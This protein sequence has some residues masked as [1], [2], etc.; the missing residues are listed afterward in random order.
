MNAKVYWLDLYKAAMLELN[1]TE[2]RN[3]I[4]L[5]EAV[6]Q[7]RSHELMSS[8]EPTSLEEKCALADAL[9]NLAML[10]R[11]ELQTPFDVSQTMIQAPAGRES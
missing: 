7:Q 1:P 4:D 9:I 11:A 5:A 8:E 6:M 2:L 3:R 10:R